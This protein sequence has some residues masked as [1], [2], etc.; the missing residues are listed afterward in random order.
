MSSHAK[1]CRYVIYAVAV[2][3]FASVVNCSG[4]GGGGSK[5]G[6]LC[7][8]NSD[9]EHNSCS[10]GVCFNSSYSCYSDSD[11]DVGATC[12]PSQGWCIRLCS[13][14]CGQ[15]TCCSYVGECC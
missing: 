2:L 1:S 15:L 11:C 10:N 4:E 14:G 6:A 3:L 12:D 13:A 7:T 9:C 5:D 8:S